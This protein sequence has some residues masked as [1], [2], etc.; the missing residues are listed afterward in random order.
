MNLY[1]L[2]EGKGK[3]NDIS[4]LNSGYDFL[5]WAMLIAFGV[6]NMVDALWDRRL[7]G[8][9]RNANRETFEKCEAAQF[10]LL[11]LELV[12][13]SLGLLVA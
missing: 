12:A 13:V 7:C 2:R 1:F 6:M 4:H 10:Q 5:I 9:W 11:V 3:Q 8:G